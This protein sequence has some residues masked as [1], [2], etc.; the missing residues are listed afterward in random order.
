M[1]DEEEF[2]RWFSM[3][4]QTLNS[5]RL[6]M[7]MG[8]FNWACFKAHQAA[9]LAVKALARGIG[10]SVYGHS[11]HKIIEKL[12]SFSFEAPKELLSKAKTLD[13][14]YIPTRYPDAWVEGAPFEYYTS[15]DS[16][17]AIKYCEKI[18]E[19]VE[20]TWKELLQKEKK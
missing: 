6:D 8:Y 4:K 3:A 17:R 13:Q 19:W 18:L 15:E 9:E 5:A 20:E 11:V 12:I 7:D 16:N 1:L 10:K 14:Y 2:N